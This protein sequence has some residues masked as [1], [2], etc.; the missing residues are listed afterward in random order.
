VRRLGQGLQQAA[1]Q[2]DNFSQGHFDTEVD[3]RGQDELSQ[4]MLALK[5]VQTRLGFELADAQRR[6][7]DEAAQREAETRVAREVNDAITAA[8]QR[9]PD[10]AH[11]AG[12]QERPSS[13]ACATG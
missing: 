12:R 4:A 3:A 9:R 1:R 13:A 2:L 10:G 11:P 6:A 8:T 5:R 7:R